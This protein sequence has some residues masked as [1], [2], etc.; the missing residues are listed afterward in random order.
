LKCAKEVEAIIDEMIETIV[1]AEALALVPEVAMFSSEANEVFEKDPIREQTIDI[2]QDTVE[3]SHVPPVS[4]F[5][6]HETDVKE[7]S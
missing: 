7:E 2:V 3:V 5:I 1:Q 6:E 4:S